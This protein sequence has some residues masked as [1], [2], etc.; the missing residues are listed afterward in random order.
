MFTVYLTPA[1]ISYL[2]QS[3]LALSI[4]IYFFYRIKKATQTAHGAQTG[5]LAGFFGAVSLLSLLLFFEASLPRGQDFYALFLQTIVLAIG[6][7]LLLQFAYRFPNLHPGLWRWEALLVLG[8]SC[9]YV[10]YE[11][12]LAFERYSLLSAGSVIWRPPY[13]DYP[14]AVGFVLAPIIFLRQAWRSSH[15]ANPSAPFWRHLWQPTGDEARTARALAQV[16]LIPVVLIL[17][18]ILRS[19][20]FIS[21]TLFSAIISAG[22]LAALATFA[23]VY[24]NYL[25]ESTSF[26]VKLAGVTL[27][28]MLAVLGMA[29]WVI[30]PI[31]AAQ[32]H[33]SLPD[34]KTFRFTPNDQGN[35]AIEQ[36]PLA[37]D[38][39]MGQNLNLVEDWDRE[40]FG[41][42]FQFPLYGQTYETMYVNMDGWIMFGQNARYSFL[43]YRYGG[44]APAIFPLF[45]DLVNS[46][47]DSN[48]YLR[49]DSDRLVLTWYRLPAFHD[50]NAIYTFQVVL[51]HSG[52]FEIS[53]NGLPESLVYQPNE[54]PGQLPWFIGVMPPGL[55]TGPKIVDFNSTVQ[56]N[57][58]KGG[59][60]Q[61]Y[62]L[63]FRQY[64]HQMLA[65][66]AYLVLGSSLLLLIATPI[67]LYA[68][69]VRPLNALQQGVRKIQS[70]D[71]DVQ[72][73]VQ[74]PDEIGFLTQAFNQMSAEQRELIQSLEERVAERTRALSEAKEAAEAANRAKS[75][76]LANMSHELRTPLNAIIGF[77]ELMLQAPNLD[78]TQHSNIETINRSSEHLL[79]LINDI[80][81]LSKIES[82]R[83]EVHEHSFDLKRMLLGLEDVFLLRA[84]QKGLSLRVELTPGLPQFISADQNKLRQVLTNLLSNAVKFT[85]RGHIAL[86]A[87]LSEEAAAPQLAEN[88]VQTQLSGRKVLHV[89]VTD[90]GIGIKPEDQER[91]FH[92]FIQVSEDQFSQQGTG[93]GLAIS[94]QYVEMMGGHLSVQSQPG[95]GSTFSF[96]IPVTPIESIVESVKL[97][98]VTGLEPNQPTYRL[99]VAEDV[100]PNRLLLIDLL[101]S[102]GFEVQAAANGQEAVEIFQ[103][104]QPHLIFM[105]LRMPVMNG[106]EATQRIKTLP[107]MPST[108]IIALTASA[109]ESDRA[110][111]LALGC[112]DFIAKPFQRQQ[113]YCALEKHLGV[114]FTYETVEPKQSST[115]QS[116]ET[117]RQMARLDPAWR[118]Q[119]RRATI[120]GDV[121]MIETLIS[122]IESTQP[123]LATLLNQW[124]FNFDYARIRN[125]IEAVELEQQ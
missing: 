40:G 24:L 64:L 62:Q 57:D 27:I 92:P 120:D 114:R 54:N 73:S 81:E 91:I 18:N 5:L 97:R 60:I 122:Q 16:F 105:D 104:W 100:K 26:I 22:I 77:S 32:Y 110:R 39:Q 6:M 90:T 8:L 83:L 125:L 74:Y 63:E 13:A 67:F 107:G 51:Y 119:M 80:L 14:M 55:S 98:R 99:L 108:I 59:V 35:Y 31:Y 50:P 71:Y 37:F 95:L 87:S 7:L 11:S 123:E 23:V 21:T 101:Q 38:E 10:F 30:S 72:V 48:L 47:N 89:A 88:V 112:D 103:S 106:D 61:D 49:Q 43:H 117:A 52:I 109:F 76:F 12:S 56:F 9:G 121:V 2:V 53:Y 44:K 84:Q 33:P 46:A 86:R 68:N 82:G 66:L 113:I 78:P 45:M 79:A 3:I 25:P 34:G 124:M 96:N 58:L 65:P 116:V 28:F 93:L 36:I 70:H 115:Q 20:Y 1:S 69:L 102:I 4:T 118:E 85:E 41:I 15:Q 17:A 19:Y 75:I 111:T 29:G 94:Q 42:N